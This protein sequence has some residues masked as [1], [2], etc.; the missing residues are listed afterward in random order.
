MPPEHAAIPDSWLRIE[1][2]RDLVATATRHAGEALLRPAGSLAPGLLAF[3]VLTSIGLADGGL[4]PRNWRMASLA[5]LAATAAF[6][7]R[8][9][10]V[11]LSRLELATLTAFAALTG[12]VA[13]SGAWS[14][15]SS[16][17]LLEAERPLLYGVCV[18]ALLVVTAREDVRQLLAGAVAAITFVSADGLAVHLFTSPPIDQF[19]GRLLYQPLGYANALGIF[20]AIGILLALGLAQTSASQS[21]RSALFASLLVLLP[22]L[23]LTSSRGAWLA[24]AAGLAVAACLGAGARVRALVAFLALIAVA[25]GAILIASHRLSATGPV[26]RNR[27]TYWRVAWHEY[28]RNPVLGSGAGTYVDYWIRERPDRSF[29][30]TA[31]NLY[32]QSLAELGP[33]GLALVLV[34]LG[35]PVAAPAGRRDP[36]VAAA[37]GGYAAYLI[38]TAVD[39]DWQLPAATVPGLVCAASLLV[40][41]RAAPATP[42]RDRAR[43]CLLV[44]VGA[45]AIVAALRLATG[46]G[47]P[48]S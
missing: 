43:V 30:R 14:G 28:E 29:T 40:L 31:H 46:P 7:V 12:W 10:R 18:L 1:P 23:A 9:R 33:V 27:S 25:S 48:G 34:A 19:E 38:H 17:A 13:L 37:T 35:L 8:R 2:I 24:L 20:A 15:E 22:T 44:A 6:A 4:L 41:G 42:L 21:V 16:V 45:L 3:G 36:L 39:W 5:L 26:G 32:L 11:V 47:L